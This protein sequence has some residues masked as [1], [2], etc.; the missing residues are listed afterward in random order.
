[1][2]FFAPP[3]WYQMPGFL[4]RAWRSGQEEQRRRASA[5]ETPSRPAA[6]PRDRGRDY[7]EAVEQIRRQVERMRPGKCCKG[8]VMVAGGK[9]LEVCSEDCE[10]ERLELLVANASVD[11]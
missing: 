7:A 8:A 2:W 10:W 4:W 5:T 9:R 1:M 6:R 3:K 11:A